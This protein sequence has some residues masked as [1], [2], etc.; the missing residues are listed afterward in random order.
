[1]FFLNS[2]FGLKDQLQGLTFNMRISHYEPVKPVK[3]KN[4]LYLYANCLCKLKHVQF[5]SKFILIEQLLLDCFLF[6]LIS[7]QTCIIMY[8]W[9][10]AENI[11]LAY[12][13]IKNMKS[14]KSEISV[15][16]FWNFITFIKSLYLVYNYCTPN[17]WNMFY[18]LSVD[19]IIQNKN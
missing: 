1:M 3:N 9:N 13:L 11:I 19:F 10:N 7:I 16:S 6:S 12:L 15:I 5:A 17:K 2:S 4:F 18:V 14:N 8:S